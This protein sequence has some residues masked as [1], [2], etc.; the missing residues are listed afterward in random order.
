M[1]EFDPE[2][3]RVIK[4]LWDIHPD[5]NRK[6]LVGLIFD[7]ASK[8]PEWNR[9]L[10]KSTNKLLKMDTT[11]TTTQEPVQVQAPPPTADEIRLRQ[12]NEV[13]VQGQLFLFAVQEAKHIHPRWKAIATTEVEKTLLVVAGAMETV[14][15]PN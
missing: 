11:T 7:E 13:R 10:I 8:D 1:E 14:G 12:K 6:E 2:V 4:G 5:L 9:L 15:T 3:L